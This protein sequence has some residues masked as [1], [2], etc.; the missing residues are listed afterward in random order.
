M[1]SLKRGS[2]SVL[3]L[4][5]NEAKLLLA[6]CK[7]AFSSFGARRLQEGKQVLYALFFC[8]CYNGSTALDNRVTIQ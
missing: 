3:F 6:V 2:K 7:R 8:A 4:L 5:Q 1:D